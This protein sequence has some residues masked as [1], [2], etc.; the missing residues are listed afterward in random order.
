MQRNRTLMYLCCG[1]LLLLLSPAHGGPA[2][3]RPVGG[4]ITPAH[5]RF[6]EIV[7]AS[8]QAPSGWKAACV[9]ARMNVVETKQSW[10][11]IFEVGVPQINEKNG[12]VT[13]A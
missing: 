12:R 2:D 7:P 5:F 3:P 8:S 13:D 11:C 1:L 6:K 4:V 10:E 9:I